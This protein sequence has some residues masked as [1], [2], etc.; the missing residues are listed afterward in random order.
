MDFRQEHAASKRQPRAGSYGLWQARHRSKRVAGSETREEDSRVKIWRGVPH[1]PGETVYGK[2]V[3]FSFPIAS[4]RRG[5]LSGLVPSKK[6]R[7]LPARSTSEKGSKRA[8]SVHMCRS[9]LKDR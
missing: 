6:P 1:A 2:G 9:I 4:S 7:T 3:A 5:K 8:R